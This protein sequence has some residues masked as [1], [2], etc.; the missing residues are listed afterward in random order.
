MRSHV[1][2]EVSLFQKSSCLLLKVM[3]V[4]F[5]LILIFPQISLAGQFSVSPI[6]VTLDQ[7]NRSGVI[8]VFNEEQ[9]P[10][11]VQMKAFLW[12]QDKEG[13]D[14][15]TET[16]DI[17][18]FPKMI[19]V[20]PNTE[21]IIR[22]GMQNFPKDR[23]KT[24]RLFVEEIPLRIRD[25]T[26][27]QVQ[28][29]VR[30][31][32]PIFV[33]PPKNTKEGA[34]EEMALGQGKLSVLVRNTGNAHFV[35]Q[36]LMIRGADQSG[37][38][39]FSRELSGWYLLSGSTRRYSTDIPIAICQEAAIFNVEVKTIE[40]TRQENFNVDKTSCSQ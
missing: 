35:I 21:R 7:G 16:S 22:L 37:Q 33:H 25:V 2:N 19:T 10:L 28:V 24:Y 36:S 34:I 12:T 30:F 38:E 15:Y 23:E 39:L 27:S 13:K 32:V 17:L 11:Q 26:D 31:G 5:A 20:M 18:F 6:K 4:F 40:F 3:F 14:Q 9:S 8:H 29:A 1:L